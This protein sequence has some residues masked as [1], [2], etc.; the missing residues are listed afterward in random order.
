MKS[1]LMGG[2]LP[3]YCTSSKHAVA[4]EVVEALLLK[5]NLL[6][7]VTSLLRVLC[8]VNYKYIHNII[9]ADAVTTESQH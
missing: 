4:C 9:D 1:H 6:F 3:I 2:I 7:N 5:H 8:T